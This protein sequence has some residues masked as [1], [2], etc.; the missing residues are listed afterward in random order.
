VRRL[1]DEHSSAAGTTLTAMLWSGRDAALAHIG[2][3]RAYLLRDQVLYH[4]TKDHTIAQLKVEAGEMSEEEAAES[5]DRFLLVGFLGDRLENVPELSVREGR[6]GDRYLLCTD[7][8]LVGDARSIHHV[9]STVEDPQRAAG[10]LVDE[11][12][13]AGGPDN[14]ACVVVDVR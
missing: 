2:N 10:R 9:L 13:A 5:K 3:S 11:A 1:C 6:I 8:L 12:N 14:V 4:I 7:G